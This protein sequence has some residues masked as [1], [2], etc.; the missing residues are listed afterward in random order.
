VS[1]DRSTVETVL[2]LV[3]SH[4]LKTGMFAG[5]NKHEVANAPGNGIRAEIWV[6]R[7]R[8]A[9]S[10]LASTSG[11]LVLNVRIRKP[12]TLGSDLIEAEM[13]AACDALMLAY[14]GDFELG[15]NARQVDIFGQHGVQLDATA[16]YLQQQDALYRVYTLNVPIVVSDLWAQTA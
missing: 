1:L 12:T 4:A 7:I 11:L 6:Q 3:E 15:G 8:P 2:A 10:G 5:V 9:S 13:L 14:T 16:G